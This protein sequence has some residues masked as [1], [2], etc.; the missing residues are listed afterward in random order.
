METQALPRLSPDAAQLADD[1]LAFLDRMFSIR[2]KAQ[3][4]DPARDHAQRAALAFLRLALA[5]SRSGGGR[6]RLRDDLRAVRS[7]PRSGPQPVS[8]GETAKRYTKTRPSHLRLVQ[9]TP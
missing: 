9:E 3:P 7:A 5:A 8:C 6:E 4:Q 2:D 1:A